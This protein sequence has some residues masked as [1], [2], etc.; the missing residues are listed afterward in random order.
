MVYYVFGTIAIALTM[1][2]NATLH[3]FKKAAPATTIV[4]PDAGV[5]TIP[6]N[7][8]RL[9]EEHATPAADSQAPAD[10]TPDSCLSAIGALPPR[11]PRFLENTTTTRMILLAPE[12]WRLPTLAETASWLR[13]GWYTLLVE[14]PDYVWSPEYAAGMLAL[15]TP[16]G[17]SAAVANTVAHKYS[18]ADF[19]VLRATA[20]A[21]LASRGIAGVVFAQ[22]HDVET[23]VHVRHFADRLLED[24][25]PRYHLP[26]QRLPVLDLEPFADWPAPPAPPPAG[27]DA[28]AP[29]A[30]L[31]AQ[32]FVRDARRGGALLHRSPD[33]LRLCTRPTRPVLQY[34]LCQP[35]DGTAESFLLEEVPAVVPRPVHPT[36][37]AGVARN[38]AA[39]RPA[40]WAL[41]LL[42]LAETRAA[43]HPD[44]AVVLQR[45]VHCA[46]SRLRYDIATLPPGA[47][48]GDPPAELALVSKDAP[49]SRPDR[50]LGLQVG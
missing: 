14:H 49:A 30:E 5:L 1:A 25:F 12:S 43:A 15:T 38:T 37:A 29:V 50:E 36:W 44:D 46:L 39:H 4:F 16:E 18:P 23:V 48:C 26:H 24:A 28:D 42:S 3:P 34:G 17:V 41:A 32:H 19:A 6:L 35:P 40:F 10:D 9:D 13:P 11:A 47:L 8:T 20:Q 7:P 2:M 31:L 27:V 21:C 33:A 22:E 45:A